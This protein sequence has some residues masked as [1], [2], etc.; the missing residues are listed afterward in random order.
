[1]MLF[2]DRTV[3]SPWQSRARIKMTEGDV[4]VA[5]AHALMNRTTHDSGLR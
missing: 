3:T 2:D 1:M 5:C 4:D